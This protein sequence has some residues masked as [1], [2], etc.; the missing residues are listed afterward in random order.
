MSEHFIELGKAAYKTVK[1]ICDVRPGED[2]LVYDDS[3]A[4]HRVVQAIAAAAHAVGGK[5]TLV[6]YETQPEVCMDPPKPMVAA[7]KAAD[8][9]IENSVN[10]LLYSPAQTEAL[11]TIRA[12]MCFGG[13][14]TAGDFVRMVA[15]V[16]YP[17]M[18]AFGELLAD[19]TQK[20]KKVRM[21]NAA[22]T[23]VVAMNG[24]RK[25][26]QF[27]GVYNMPKGPMQQIM[28]AGQVGWCPLEETIN[29]TIV[30]DGYLWP[31]DEIGPLPKPPVKITVKKGV[32]VDI[33][34]N[35]NGVVFKKWLEAF[36]DPKMYRIAHYTYGICPTAELKPT[37][38]NIAEGERY[39]GNIEFGMGMQGP[40]I[41]G[42]GWT[43]AAHSDGTCAA[44]SVYLDGEKIEENG[45]FIH[46]G[47]A[48]LAKKMGVKGY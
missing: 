8:V 40:L 31:P 7:M 41:G 30:Y 14:Y 37:T 44:P 17:S 24:G 23:D 36:K 1:D 12:Y 20:A 29:G 35:A 16:D 43:A 27:G 39:F 26:K 3:Q 47:L 11:K 2:V 45:K 34:Q 46:P 13:G 4:D 25:V 5:V 18:I 48:K 10:Y 19:M 15:K 38:R 33:E 32:I 9:L 6:T 42:K 28:P 22:G 21:T